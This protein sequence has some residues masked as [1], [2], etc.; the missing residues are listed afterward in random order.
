M[1][2]IYLVYGYYCHSPKFLAKFFNSNDAFEFKKSYETK[3]EKN[4]QFEFC[5]VEVQ[6]WVNNKNM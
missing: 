3:E 1:K 6:S 5:Y 2:S 4:P